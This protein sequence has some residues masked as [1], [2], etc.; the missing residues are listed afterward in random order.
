MVERGHD[1]RPVSAWVAAASAVLGA[2][3]AARAA[4]AARRRRGRKPPADGLGRASLKHAFTAYADAAGRV[5]KLSFAGLRRARGADPPGRQ[6]R[7]LRLRQHDAAGRAPQGGARREPVVFATNTLVLA[8]PAGR[9]DRRPRTTW[10][11]RRRRSRSALEERCRS[12]TTRAR[13]SAKLPAGAGA[14]DPRQRALQRARRG[15]RRRQAHPGRGRRRLRL[16][17]P[18]SRDR[19]RAARRSSCR[20]S[21]SPSVAY[22]VAVVKGAKHP[23]RRPGRSSTAC[24]SGDGRGRSTTPGFVPPPAMS[25]LTPGSSGA[26]GRRA[27]AGAGLPGRCRS[28]RSSPTRRRRASCREPRRSRPPR[29]ALRLSLQT[30]L[31]ALASSSSSARPPRTCWPRAAS[32]GAR[33]W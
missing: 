30:T 32:A 24:S 28:S 25:A 12:A 3:R 6:A 10:Q 13:C 29:D 22:G 1:R 14:G 11:A 7:R 9:Q 26:A 20:P 5:R 19:R 18:T 4:A 2:A 21:S 17:R 31:T 23:R 15:R 8:V 16:R 27:G 33:W